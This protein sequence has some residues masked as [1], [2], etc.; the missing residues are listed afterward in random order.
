VKGAAESGAAFLGS[1]VLHLEPGVREHFDSFLSAE[2]PG[3][4]PMY[5]RLYPGR[6]APAGVER[7]LGA[8]V[9]ELRHRYGLAERPA[10]TTRGP[11]TEL[12]PATR[13]EDDSQ[14][15]LGL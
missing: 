2:A 3:L 9:E 14:L 4:L 12:E 10:A 7:S 11:A 1:G 15:S 6:R 5:R 8:T 13:P